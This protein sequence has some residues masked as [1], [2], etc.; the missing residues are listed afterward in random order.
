MQLIKI[1]S[2]NSSAVDT[3]DMIFKQQV[4]SIVES[5][6]LSSLKDH[7]NLANILLS[8]PKLPDWYSNLAAELSRM[9]A[10]SA[11]NQ[12]PF[13][14]ELELKRWAAGYVEHV[15][16]KADKRDRLAREARAIA[17]KACHG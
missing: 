5:F 15:M 8:H 7:A 14:V 4:Q 17:E 9:E 10:E 3:R 11:V 12:Q 1:A 6:I 16:T 2:D 13:H